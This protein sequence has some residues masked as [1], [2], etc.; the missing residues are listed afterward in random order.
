M[1]ISPNIAK[2]IVLA[3]RKVEDVAKDSRNEFHKYKYAASED[4]TDAAREA[5]NAAG[6]ACSRI[7]WEIIPGSETVEDKI[8]VT[9]M[10]AHESGDVVVLPPTETPAI[11]EKG[12]PM[13][14]AVAA[15]LTLN[16]S[17]FLLG[18]LEIKREEEHEVDKRDDR[19]HTPRRMQQRPQQASR[20]AREQGDAKAKAQ[21]QADTQTWTHPETGEAIPVRGRWDEIANAAELLAFLTVRKSAL[22]AAK[23]AGRDVD[24]PLVKVADK[25][26]V[27]PEDAKRWL[28]AA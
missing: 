24:G 23:A 19:E 10:L 11:P 15:A 16:Q 14:K 8:R 21:T 28:A 4:V 2:A 1:Q 5:L 27:D 20:A 18:L 22:I 25:V 13:D 26:G 6:L 12:R 17:Y 3:Q 9:Y 7:A